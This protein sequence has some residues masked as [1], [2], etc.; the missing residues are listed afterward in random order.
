MKTQK[1]AVV[2]HSIVILR[3]KSQNVYIQ[4]KQ[5]FI[6]L[7]ERITV[8]CRQFVITAGFRLNCGHTLVG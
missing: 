6:T 2:S 4:F 5:A 1:F 8:I 3:L 7:T